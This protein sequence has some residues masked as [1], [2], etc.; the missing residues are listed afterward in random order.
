MT[1]RTVGFELADWQQDAVG[2]WSTG[3]SQ[4]YT[5]TLEVFTG[6]GKTLMA[7]QCAAVASREAPDLRLAIVV[8]TEALGHQWI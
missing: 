4:P 3:A 8:P 6:G 7:L 1:F 2:A 5:G